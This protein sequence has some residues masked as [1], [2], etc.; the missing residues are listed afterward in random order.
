MTP[1]EQL[2]QHL[3]R[4]DHALTHHPS[5]TVDP[6]TVLDILQSILAFIREH[7]ELLAMLLAWL[8]N[9]G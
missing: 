4:L 7:P 9:R 1:R 6:T 5:A 3:Q 8:K 2:E